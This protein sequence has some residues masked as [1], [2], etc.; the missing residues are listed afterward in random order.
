MDFSFKIALYALLRCRVYASFW[1]FSDWEF[2]RAPT[3][4]L[5]RASS[6]VAAVL[7]LRGQLEALSERAS[8]QVQQLVA[9]GRKGVVFHVST[10]DPFDVE[11]L[12]LV[13][14]FAF[15]QV[16]VDDVDDEILELSHRGDIER[17][18]QIRV[19]Q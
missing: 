17:G 12:F 8:L 7:W 10:R 9:K 16:G 14:Q 18:E 11:H 1:S 4:S 2:E 6:S 5:S 15:E 13:V 19:R 3:I